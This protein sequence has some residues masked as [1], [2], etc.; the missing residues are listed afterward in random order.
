MSTWYFSKPAKTDYKFDVYVRI[1][2][3]KPQLNAQQQQK[4]I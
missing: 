4:P 2:I 1:L 3:T